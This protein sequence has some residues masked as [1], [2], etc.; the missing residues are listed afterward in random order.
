MIPTPAV[1][2]EPEPEPVKPEPEPEPEPEPVKPEPEPE[3]EPV[4]PEPKPVP[5]PDSKPVPADCKDSL[6]DIKKNPFDTGAYEAY[7]KC[8]LA[9]KE[10]K[11]LIIKLKMGLR[12]NPGFDRGWYYQGEAYSGLGDK[13]QAS[14]AYSKACKKGVNEACSKF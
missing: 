13:K 9:R 8:A 12:D 14:F 7:A 4:K 2:P 11:P 1:E 6:A 10:F 5:E 3:P